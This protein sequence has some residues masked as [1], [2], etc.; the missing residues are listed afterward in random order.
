MPLPQQLSDFVFHRISAFRINGLQHNKLHLIGKLNA[1]HFFLRSGNRNKHN[2]ILIKS[3]AVLAAFIQH[4]DYFKRNSLY[5]DIFTQGIHVSEQ[6]I[7][8]SLPQNRHFG[9]IFN[10]TVVKHPA[11]GQ[12]PVFNLKMTPVGSGNLG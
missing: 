11:I 8:H 5:A 1:H 3:H 10:V 2:V 6:F 7:N 4:A 12:I 9:G